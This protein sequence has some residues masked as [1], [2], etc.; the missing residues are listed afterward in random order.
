[1]QAFNNILNGEQG[2]SVRGKLNNALTSIISGE[3]GINSIWAS[4]NSERTERIEADQALQEA[5]DD[6]ESGTHEALHIAA[7]VENITPESVSPAGPATDICFDSVRNS[8]Y[9]RLYNRLIPI[10]QQIVKYAL[11]TLADGSLNDYNKDGQWFTMGD[12]CFVWFSTGFKEILPD[13]LRDNKQYARKNGEWA[14]VS[15]VEG[16][17]GPAGPQ[18]PVGPQGNSG[19]ASSDGIESWTNLDDPEDIPED[20]EQLVNVTGAKVAALMFANRKISDISIST[21]GR[22]IT[23]QKTDGTEVEF[24]VEEGLEEL[25]D[26]Q[27]EDFTLDIVSPPA[28]YVL[29]PLTKTIRKGTTVDVTGLSS[30]ERILFYSDDTNYQSVTTFPA[31]INEDSIAIKLSKVENVTL[32]CS[33]PGRAGRVTELE[34]EVVLLDNRLSNTEESISK[35]EKDI[36]PLFNHEEEEYE[37]QVNIQ[38]TWTDFDLPRIIKAG[39]II[40]SSSYDGTHFFTIEGTSTFEHFS[41]FPHVAQ[42]NLT[43]LR[44]GQKTN[45]TLF[46]TSPEKT[47]EVQRLREDVDNNTADVKDLQL[48]VKDLLVTETISTFTNRVVDQYGDLPGSGAQNV[49][50]VDLSFIKDNKKIAVQHSYGPYAGYR[51]LDIVW[52]KTWPWDQDVTGHIISN[53]SLHVDNLSDNGKYF[54]IDI[55]NGAKTLQITVPKETIYGVVYF[56]YTGVIVHPM[57]DSTSLEKLEKQLIPDTFLPNR[58]YG[59]VGDTL[60]IFTRGVV[61]SYSPYRFFSQFIAPF[62]KEYPRYL[63]LT[64]TSSGDY[65]IKHRLIM[66]DFSN[67][68]VSSNLMVSAKPT[69]SPSSA[70][71]VLCVGDS[72]S[73][74]GIWENELKRRLTGSGGMPTGDA[75]TNINFVGRLSR[76]DSQ[77][78]IKFEAT[79]GWSWHTFISPGQDAIRLQVSNVTNIAIGSQ[80]TYLANDGKTAKLEVAEVNVTSGSGNIRLLYTYDSTT[81]NPPASTSGICSRVSGSGDAQINFSSYS[82]EK[83]SP[84]YDEDEDKVTFIPY[85]ETYCQNHIDVCVVFLEPVNYGKMGNE[86]L[87]NVMADM[88]IFIDTLHSEFPSCKIIVCSGVVCSTYRGI[89]YNYGAESNWSQFGSDKAEFRYRKLVNDFV[90]SDEYKDFVFMAD[91]YAQFD[92][93]HSYPISTKSVNT[94]NSATETIGTN[95]VHPTI[96]GYMMYADAFYRT[97]VNCIL[98]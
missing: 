16:P 41:S 94:R 80:Y 5:I 12:R 9:W 6:I 73:S 96:E 64:P 87:D 51:F 26:I 65:S 72:L 47:G 56:D 24:H 10:H 97:F 58:I 45:V 33:Y 55:P 37:I 74:G 27:P 59:V 8:F 90:E 29:V 79:G 44:I 28:P 60:Q 81:K 78:D 20:T 83:F 54:D 75:L 11:S 49:V 92:A 70:M 34:N 38:A 98:N 30:G 7:I 63:E 15:G 95:G 4:I 67:K 35:V 48:Y 32:E 71:N 76:Q 43:K 69:T 39:D 86:S 85:A 46:C 57:Q 91:T 40:E 88:K 50:T 62:G 93:E 77:Y 82:K 42:N 23:I 52:D 84:F 14:E 68:E 2:A 22:K 89:E 53:G 3:E 31:V 21:N 19:V 61:N 18:G 17:A 25:L 66:E 36:Y 1:M 13:A